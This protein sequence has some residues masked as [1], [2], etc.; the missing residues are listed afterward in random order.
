MFSYTLSV[1]LLVMLKNDEWTL[2]VTQTCVQIKVH[3]MR[4]LHHLNVILL[5]TQ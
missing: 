1:K 4:K 5:S 2:D 3:K